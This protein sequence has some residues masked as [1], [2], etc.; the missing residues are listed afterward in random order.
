MPRAIAAGNLAV[1]QYLLIGTWEN[2]DDELTYHD[3]PRNLTLPL[4]YNVMPLPQKA[5]PPDRPDIGGTDYGGFILKNFSFKETI[6]FNGSNKPED[7]RLGHYDPEALAVV[8]SAPNR[9]GTYTQAS[10]AIF[11]DQQ[12]RFAEGPDADKV[13]HVEN[14]AWLHLGSEEQLSGPYSN[15]PPITNE[16]VLRQPAYLTIAKQISVPHGNSVLALGTVDLYDRGSFNTDLSGT[17][18]N[19]VIPG[20]PMIPDANAP[21]PAPADIVTS[22]Y[23]DPYAATLSTLA[24]FENPN[25]AFTLNPNVPLQLAVD[26]INPVCH[27][28][29]RVTTDPIFAGVSDPLFGGLGVVTNIPFEQRKARVIGYTADYWLLSKDSYHFDYLA[30][31]QNIFMDLEIFLPSENNFVRRI[32]PH[33]T[34][35]TVK[36]APGT[37]TEARYRV[38][39]AAFPKH[40]GPNASEKETDEHSDAAV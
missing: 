39:G 28:H 10:H 38:P 30:Y 16:R 40:N 19:T 7:E 27:I 35:N 4:S 5:V 15:S 20:K 25:P 18:S 31:N 17:G 21:Y 2:P 6:R 22:H 34:T 36:R 32:F 11:Y 12:V 14:G 26:E 24:D 8:A 23:S 33:V 37:P 29:W 13:V 1:F 9:G 3:A